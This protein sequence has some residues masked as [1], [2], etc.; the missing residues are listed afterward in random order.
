M[1]AFKA[2]LLSIFAVTMT[3][4]ATLAQAADSKENRDKLLSNPVIRQNVLEGAADSGVIVE[5]PCASMDYVARPTV[6]IYEALDFD[7]EGFATKGAWKETIDAK[8]CGMTRILNVA[9]I[10]EGPRKLHFATIFP[11]NTHAGVKLQEDTL[12]YAI[13]AALKAGGAREKDC[14]VHY[15]KDTQYLGDDGPPA[16]T[17]TLAPWHELWTI[18]TCKYV[19]LVPMKFRPTPDRIDF[20]ADTASI[21]IGPRG[22]I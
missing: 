19:Y 12:D 6:F 2:V 21:K 10:V 1:M 7:E 4:T 14:K 11:G 3:S 8:G 16:P 22:A 15:I 5:H 13:D 20:N 9:V 18:E 17:T